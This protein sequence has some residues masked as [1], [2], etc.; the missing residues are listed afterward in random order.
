MFDLIE[1]LVKDPNKI[2]RMSPMG[3]EAETWAR[4]K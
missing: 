2:H 4:E 1:T 3:K